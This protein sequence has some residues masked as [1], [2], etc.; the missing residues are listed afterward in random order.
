L[1][2]PP[3][4]I[5]QRH[6]AWEALVAQCDRCNKY[7]FKREL[8]PTTIEAGGES[9]D[10]LFCDDCFRLTEADLLSRV[11]DRYKLPE[12]VVVFLAQKYRESIENLPNRVRP[13]VHNIQVEHLLDLWIAQKGLCALTGR[14][15]RTD[16]FGKRWCASIDRISNA[17]GYELGNLQLVCA[18]ANQMKGGMTVAELGEWCAAVV[19]YALREE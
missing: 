5:L 17:L 15:M 14:K 3:Q 2:L 13:Y 18:A 7:K 9:K 6:R 4:N 10:Y 8:Q 12:Q 16:R 19:R 1:R 11:A